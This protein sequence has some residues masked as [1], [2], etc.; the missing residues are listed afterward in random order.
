[1][2]RRVSFVL[3]ALALHLGA[4]PAVASPAASAAGPAASAVNKPAAR[5][6]GPKVIFDDPAGGQRSGRRILDA[7]VRLIQQTRRG[8]VI[9]LATFILN[10]PAAAGALIAAHRRGVA[11]RIVLDD[12]SLSRR[13]ARRVIRELG[14]NP[15]HRSFVR[16]CRRA[17]GGRFGIQHAK[18]MSISDGRL[19]MISSSNV[20]R[21]TRQSNDALFYRGHRRLYRWTVHVLE[22]LLHLKRPTR[23]LTAPGMSLYLPDGRRYRASRDPVRRVLSDVTCRVRGFRTSIRVAMWNWSASRQH[24]AAQ[25]RRLAAAG[26]RVQVVG[27][28]AGKGKPWRKL[29]APGAGKV[30][31]RLMP[32][33]WMQH[34]K[35]ILIDGF[36]AH[37]R[38]RRLLQAGSQNFT[39][40][41]AGRSNEVT[42]L[43]TNRAVQRRYAAY[44]RHV[45]TARSRPVR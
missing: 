3:L 6:S 8:S 29:V 45:L 28:R 16:I 7:Q 14:R 33:K 36:D 30:A 21:I 25:L 5:A 4:V 17:C 22:R 32:R 13:Q 42:I 26:C 15:R 31:V 39:S 34:S 24:L 44:F 11:V 23:R 38:R 40:W 10:D 18:L 2:L 41:A 12:R 43:A 20:S 37:R 27:S 19:V 1:M 9:R 35:V